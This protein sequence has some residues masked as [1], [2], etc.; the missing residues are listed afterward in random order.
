MKTNLLILT[1]LIFNI[2]AFAENVFF[3]ENELNKIKNGTAIE[4][5]FTKQELPKNIFLPDVIKNGN[6]DYVV[7]LKGKINTKKSS[8]DLIN[9]LLNVS[10]LKG[11]KYYSVT[12]D[13]IKTLVLKSYTVTKSG[14]KKIPDITIR[15]L[16][17]KKFSTFYNQKGNRSGM[18]TYIANINV[19]KDSS[20]VYIT[21]NITQS[22]PMKLLNVPIDCMCRYQRMFP[23]KDGFLY[24]TAIRFKIPAFLPRKKTA[25][26][27]FINR[28]NAF[29]DL[30][31]EKL[32]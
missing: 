12:T 22:L 4:T 3:S 19:E 21:R 15:S 10:A 20:I 23:T 9:V 11:L 27:S 24:Y 13:K 32:K 5:V 6:F 14:F 18:V 17:Q 16:P 25:K 2:S 30:Y 1:I 7:I 31:K 26:Q 28:A 8:V 29:L